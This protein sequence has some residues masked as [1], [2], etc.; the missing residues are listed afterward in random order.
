MWLQRVPLQQWGRQ[1]WS[2]RGRRGS[3]RSRFVH[4]LLPRSRAG[5]RNSSRTRILDL[6]IT[7]KAHERCRCQ[8][9]F[10]GGDGGCD[11]ADCC[12]HH[13]RNWYCAQNHVLNVAR[14]QLS[15]THPIM[16]APLG[17]QYSTLPR[18]FNGDGPVVVAN[19]AGEGGGGG[20]RPQVSTGKHTSS[21][22]ERKRPVNRSVEEQKLLS[23]RS[24]LSL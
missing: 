2:R 15:R 19:M 9:Y 12:R 10:M 17:D 5:P 7:T 3:Q 16:Q 24:C 18:Y 20:G 4:E 21:S 6:F 11:H 23:S 14:G 1:R 13:T 22:E 8:R